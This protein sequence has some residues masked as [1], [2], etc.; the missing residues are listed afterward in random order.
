M[1]N[2]QWKTED[3]GQSFPTASGSSRRR[4]QCGRKS[5]RKVPRPSS[6]RV[7]RPATIKRKATTKRAQPGKFL[8]R[9]FFISQAVRGHADSPENKANQPLVGGHGP[10]V[11]I[12]PKPPIIV[13]NAQPP[14]R[15]PAQNSDDLMGW[16]GR[17]GRDA[18]IYYDAGRL[19]LD[20]VD[21]RP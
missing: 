9:Y 21:A 4:A 18:H 2:A 1:S 15:D 12:R 13:S 14:G 20:S 3:K 16:S 17:A 6:F 10:N 5:G 8:L 11:M 7:R 19:F